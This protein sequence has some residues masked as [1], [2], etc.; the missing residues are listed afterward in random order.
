MYTRGG[1][2]D[3]DTLLYWTVNALRNHFAQLAYKLW[4]DRPDVVHVERLM[5][6][7]S[8]SYAA[9]AS[10]EIGGNVERLMV[11]CCHL[12]PVAVMASAFCFD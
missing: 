4:L 2:G 12:Y 7:C 6:F 10:L 11:F 1:R 8:L 9:A 5:A 3:T